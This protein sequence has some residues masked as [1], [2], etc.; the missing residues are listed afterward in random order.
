MYNEEQLLRVLRIKQEVGSKR[1][2]LHSEPGPPLGKIGDLVPVTDP[3][4][5]YVTWQFED[6]VGD[7]NSTKGNY[8]QSEY[9]GS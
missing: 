4:T 2:H 6:E 9:S 7:R 1:T 3:I 5:K 8:T